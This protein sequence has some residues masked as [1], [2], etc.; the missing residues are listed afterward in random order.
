MREEARLYA[1]FDE[2]HAMRATR[3]SYA[4]QVIEDARYQPMHRVQKWRR[5]TARK[6][7]VSGACPQR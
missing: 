5:W 4:A 1:T 7:A 2:S 3:V 6:R